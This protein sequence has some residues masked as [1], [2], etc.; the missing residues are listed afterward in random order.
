VPTAQWFSSS[1]GPGLN[2]LLG[3]VHPFD[4]QQL[5]PLYNTHR[6]YV[7]KVV[8]SVNAL[9][10][11]RYILRE[12]GDELIR[13]AENSDVPTLADIPSDIPDNLKFLPELR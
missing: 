13:H 9:V 3:F 7:E 6:Q 8:H 12:D 4:Q 1:P 10:N 2:F 11:Q 5:K